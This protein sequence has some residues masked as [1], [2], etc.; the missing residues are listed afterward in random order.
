MLLYRLNLGKGQLPG[1]SCLQDDLNPK[2]AR[3]LALSVQIN[4]STSNRIFLMFDEV[5]GVRQRQFHTNA[6]NDLG[7][8][9]EDQHVF[10]HWRFIININKQDTDTLSFKYQ[11]HTLVHHSNNN[12]AGD[13]ATLLWQRPA[14]T[15]AS[16]W[17]G[18][19]GLGGCRTTGRKP[20][21]AI[22]GMAWPSISS[23]SEVQ[24]Q[25]LCWLQM[26]L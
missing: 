22:P 15:L 17:T 25:F 3:D 24:C 18:C 20:M 1:L 6:W 14:T 10:F 19:E 21:A 11:M 9:Q 5:Q 26:V 23:F 2:A 13:W 8:T 4:V 16:L 12:L 7:W